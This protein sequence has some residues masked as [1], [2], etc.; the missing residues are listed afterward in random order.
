MTAFIRYLALPQLPLLLFQLHPKTQPIGLCS[1]VS[2]GDHFSYESA[3]WTHSLSRV[4]RVGTVPKFQTAQLLLRLPNKQAVF[5]DAPVNGNLTAL[6][7]GSVITEKQHSIERS[8]VYKT[9]QTDIKPNP[10]SSVPLPI[11]LTSTITYM[12]I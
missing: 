4:G 6:V 7:R 11:D 2:L 8:N 1:T 12:Y 5:S 10:F 9:I 3:S